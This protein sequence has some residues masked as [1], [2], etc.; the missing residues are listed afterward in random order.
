MNSINWSTA[1]PRAANY[2]QISK[3]LADTYDDF[4][5]PHGVQKD[6]IQNGRDA[7]IGKGPLRFSFAVIKNTSGSFLAMTDEGTSGLT[8]AVIEAEDLEKLG[9]DLSEEER[10]ARFESFAFTKSNPDA[11]GARGQGKFI[12]LAA[13][14]DY[15]IYYDS[16][17]TDGS[18]RLGATK[19]TII[20]CPMLHWDGE[21]GKRQLAQLTGLEPLKRV[22]TRVLIV[23]PTEEMLEY[24]TNQKLA[25]AIQETWF[26]ALEKGEVVVS[27]SDGNKKQ[28][29]LVPKPFPLPE[30]DGKGVKVW[31]KDDD[32]IDTPNGRLRIKRLHVAVFGE[33][34]PEEMREVA[35]IQGGMKICSIKFVTAPERIRQR[36]VGF[37]EFDR[38]L[39]RELRQNQNPNHYDLQWRRM[40]PRN[41]KNYVESELREFGERKLGL[42]KDPRAQRNAL[43]AE[44]EGWALRE[45]VAVTKDFGLSLASAGINRPAKPAPANPRKELGIAFQNLQYPNPE[46]PQRVDLGQRVEDFKLGAFNRTDNAYLVAIRMFLLHGNRQQLQ[47]LDERDIQLQAHKTS[48]YGPFSFDVTSEIFPEAGRYVLRALLIDQATGTRLDEISR[49]FWFAQDPPFRA[50]FEVQAAPLLDQNRQWRLSSTGDDGY[51]VY[52]NMAHPAYRVIE[53][54]EAIEQGSYLFECFL[55]A[56]LQIL[57]RQPQDRRAD[58]VLQWNLLEDDAETAYEEM[59]RVLAD[60]RARRFARELG[61]PVN[62]RNR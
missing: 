44:A 38:E 57:L 31:L 48:V 62:G 41:I 59:V 56:A 1:C 53:G 47:I 52:Y 61:G 3:N 36:L 12:F 19:A 11:L 17:R 49:Q 18:Y 35:V 24:V 15:T 55:E 46:K 51:V 25:K 8:G 28:S 30:K 13:S 4:G 26:R 10:W 20:G 39:D 58:A 42:F 34:I 54:G 43:Q 16:Y 40:V 29:V 5:V 60:V 6:A 23:N 2:I 45:L 21:E 9:E 27:V 50:P 32:T 33:A 37:I 22:G 7:V 14:K